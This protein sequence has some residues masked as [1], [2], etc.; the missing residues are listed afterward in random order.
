M[1][2]AIRTMANAYYENTGTRVSTIR[3]GPR[4]M[5]GLAED[6]QR[7]FGGRWDFDKA[8]Y[9]DGILIETQRDEGIA[10]S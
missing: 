7:R 9:I 3:L 1:I 10:F 4:C 5:Y 8:C 2:D 6:L